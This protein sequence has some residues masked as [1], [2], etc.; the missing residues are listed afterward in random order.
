[1]PEGIGAW[2]GV[3]HAA[4]GPAASPAMVPD[5]SAP[6]RIGPFRVV[7]P[8]SGREGCMLYEGRREDG[9]RAALK[10][11]DLRSATSGAAAEM[12]SRLHREAAV[13]EAL[14]HPG[15][16]RHLDNG[17]GEAHA[18]LALELLSGPDLATALAGKRIVDVLQQCRR[19]LQALV[20]LH[21]QGVVHRDLKPHNVVFDARRGPVIC[22]LGLAHVPDSLLTQRGEM[23]GTPAYMAPECF[24]AAAVDARADLFSVG[25]MLY[26]L[27]TG[28]LPFEGR[29]SGEIMLAIVQEE[30]L[31]PSSLNAQVAPALDAVLARALAKSP[32][33]RFATAGGFDAALAS[34]AAGTT[35]ATGAEPAVQP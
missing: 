16:V 29:N 12:R 21:A 9:L 23:L 7:R 10:F 14:R 22:D 5:M 35:A 11:L 30:P 28:R 32:A 3:E 31:P 24:L 34:A 27:L 4:V 13:L 15:V 19:V 6:T 33:R 26:E 8:L 17:E 25:V 1:M 2:G 18:W 20:H